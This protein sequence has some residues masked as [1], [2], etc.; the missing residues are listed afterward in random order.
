[1]GPKPEG[2]DPRVFCFSFLRS[3]SNLKHEEKM[4]NNHKALLEFPNIYKK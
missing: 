1:M 2:F 3:Q 4:G